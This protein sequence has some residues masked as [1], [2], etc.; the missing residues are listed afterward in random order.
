MPPKP[1][2]YYG[3]TDEKFVLHPVNEQVAVAGQDLG[4]VWREKSFG[5]RAKLGQQ[6]G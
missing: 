6:G 3:S 5:Q 2:R 4:V 1:K